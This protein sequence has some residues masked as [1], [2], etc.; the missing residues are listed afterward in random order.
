[1]FPR[2][3]NLEVTFDEKIRATFTSEFAKMNLRLRR[4]I[5]R[6]H[7]SDALSGRRAVVH[8]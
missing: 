5:L 1:M 2:A 7:L 8:D 4:S 6:A 3:R